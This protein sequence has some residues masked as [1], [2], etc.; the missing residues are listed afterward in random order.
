MKKL[1]VMMFAMLAMFVFASCKK[2]SISDISMT[3][4]ENL[5]AG[6]WKVVYYFDNGEG[7]SNNFNGYE[8]QIND[9]G[10]IIAMLGTATFTGT[11]MIKTSDDDLNFNEEIEFT[12]MGDKQMDA[13]D[14]SW[15][16]MELNETIMNLIDDSGS[17]E[18][19]FEKL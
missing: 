4:S 5:A 15:V 18:I 7:V 6:N 2:E 12:I 11:W 10:T 19:Y 13:L 16:L 1:N 9:D 8:F 17:E 3:E 14:G